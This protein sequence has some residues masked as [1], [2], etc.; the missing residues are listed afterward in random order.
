M[1]RRDVLRWVSA[2]A[3][4]AGSNLFSQP[5][6]LAPLWAK[7]KPLGAKGLPALKSP[8]SS[9]VLTSPN[10]VQLVNLPLQGLFLPGFSKKMT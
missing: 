6:P 1:D 10:Q 7:E 8:T 3:V 2:G 5:S 9:T 4:A